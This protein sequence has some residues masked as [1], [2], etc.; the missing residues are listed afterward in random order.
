MNK[1]IIVAFIATLK[2]C[3]FHDLFKERVVS[4]DDIIINNNVSKYE[5]LTNKKNKKD[6]N[7]LIIIEEKKNNEKKDYSTLFKNNLEIDINAF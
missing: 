1:L 4:L 7:I 3:N 2:T 5:L 6:N